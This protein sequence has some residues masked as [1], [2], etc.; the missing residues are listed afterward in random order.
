MSTYGFAILKLVVTIVAAL[1]AGA[2]QD[3]RSIDDPGDLAEQAVKAN[4][5][6]ASM[7]KQIQ[8]LGQKAE[9]AVKWNDP[10]ISVEYSNVPW[11]TWSLGDS[12]MSG[13]LVKLAQ[14]ITLPGKN[15][16]RK[17]TYEAAQR[18]RSL[19]LDEARNQLVASVHAIYWRLTLVRNLR[20]ITGRHVLLVKQLEESARAKYT[21]GSIGQHD[22]MNL[23]V[24]RHRLED[25]LEDYDQQDS[26]LTAELNE[27]LH[28][29][30]TTVIRT[31]Q[32]F[33]DVENMTRML[34]MLPPDRDLLN[35]ARVNRPLLRLMREQ[36]KE[37]RIRAKQVAYER[38]PDFTVWAGYR[39]RAQ[40]GIDGGTDFF[41]LGLSVPIPFDYTSRSSHDSESQDL[42]AEARVLG[43]SSIADKIA[44]QIQ[45][46]LSTMKRAAGKIESYESRL[47]PEA[48]RT[49]E[50]TLAAYQADRAD[51]ATLFRAELRLLDFERTVE[52]AHSS[53]LVNAAK[54][55]AV[56]GSK[57]FGSNIVQE[58]KP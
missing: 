31:P 54:L 34:R 53:F 45:V 9:A 20:N 41:S 49:L 43:A 16:L 35:S 50:M 44:A 37:H 48:Q 12:A 10:V 46:H 25:D 57:L 36:A 2:G 52:K 42:L 33:P 23:Q 32:E 3:S 58:K 56:V 22:V 51:F 13:I 5:S 39:F 17:A 14:K 21:V 7:V 8:S 4:P 29:D 18:V 40:A 38:W 28:R 11:D 6:L 26:V 24:A 19:A 30:V 27:A 47:I 55:E 15:E 1:S